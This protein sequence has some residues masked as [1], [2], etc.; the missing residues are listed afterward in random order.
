MKFIIPTTLF[1]I[2]ALHLSF[3]QKD[4]KIEGIVVEQDSNIPLE[5][6]TITFKT[7]S[8]KVVTGGITD[9]KGRFSIEAPPGTYNISVEYISYKTK[10]YN[11]KV[12]SKDIN[13]GTVSLVLDVESLGEVTVIAERTTV[14][15]KLDKKI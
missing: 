11:D 14:E 13:L 7:K 9:S 15:I 12:I 2:F 4:L 8:D 1:L 10:Y 6:A 3:A 5:Y